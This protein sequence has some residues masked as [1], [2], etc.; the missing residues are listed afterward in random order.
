VTGGRFFRGPDGVRIWVSADGRVRVHGATHT[1]NP[2]QP[3]FKWFQIARPK[4]VERYIERKL[5]DGT[6]TP[7]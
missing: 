1:S 6:W 5:A 7:E 3:A 2:H 4:N